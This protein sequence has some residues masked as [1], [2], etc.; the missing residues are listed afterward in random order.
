MRRARGEFPDIGDEELVVRALLGEL[1]AFDELVRRFR[2]AVLAVAEG[3]LGAGEAA[4]DVAQEAFLLAFKALPQL[5]DP[6]CFGAWLCAITRHRARRVARGNGRWQPTGSQC[7]DDPGDPSGEENQP[8]VV[9]PP[10]GN[11]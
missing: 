5:E 6:A 11:D 9:Q 1:E 2:G 8:G 4:R 10:V 7:A 3:A